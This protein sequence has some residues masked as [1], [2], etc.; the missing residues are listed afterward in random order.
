MPINTEYSSALVLK[1]YTLTACVL[2][3]CRCQTIINGVY[4][5]MIP[6]LFRW[7]T[8]PFEILLSQRNCS[9]F[10]YSSSLPKVILTGTSLMHK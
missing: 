7:S 4:K 1:I 10:I 5:Y 6:Y 9:W 8:Q 3:S 2:S